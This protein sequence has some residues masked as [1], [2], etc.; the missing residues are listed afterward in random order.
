MAKWT[1]IDSNH[2][3]I[4]LWATNFLMTRQKLTMQWILSVSFQH[5][6]ICRD[7]TFDENK[8]MWLL[9]YSA[10]YDLND[11][12]AFSMRAD[13]NHTNEKWNVP[14]IFSINSN[15]R[16]GKER[17]IVDTRKVKV[18]QSSG[19]VLARC[20]VLIFVFTSRFTIYNA[21]INRDQFPWF[22]TAGILFFYLIFFYLQLLLLLLLVCTNIAQKICQHL[23]TSKTHNCDN[24]TK[25]KAADSHHGKSHKKFICFRFC[26]SFSVHLIYNSNQKIVATRKVIFRK[27]FKYKHGKESLPKTTMHN[28]NDNGEMFI[29]FFLS[30]RCH[31]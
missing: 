1:E 23:Q 9:W 17:R 30:S 2:G 4:F 20:R 13:D 15:H 28:A 7:R 29:F 27:Y 3:H 31:R 10:Q 24:Q 12:L 5:K 25:H 6:F 14:R 21:Q 22:T 26:F 8:T 18:K 16:W 19:P 11:D